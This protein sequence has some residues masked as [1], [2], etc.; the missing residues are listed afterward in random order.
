MKSVAFAGLLTAL[1]G[2]QAVLATAEWGQ[3]DG[4]GYG[5]HPCDAGLTCVYVNDYYSQCQK[6]TGATTTTSRP[7]GTT[8]T[9]TSV[10]TT[11][12]G[13]SPNT[14]SLNTKYKAKGKQYWGTCGDQ[15]TLSQSQCAQ[16]VKDDFGA[17]TPENSLKW[18]ATCVVFLYMVS[19][20]PL[21]MQ[22]G[23][24]WV[25]S[26]GDKNT[27]TTVI[28]NH[29][30]TLVTRYKGKIAKW[31]VVNEMFNEDG[32]VRS[33]VFSN[34]LGTTF[35][36]IAFNAA[37]AADGSAKLYINDYNLDSVNSKVNGLV[38]LVNQKKSAGVPIDGI[39]SQAH[40]SAGQT[41]GFLAALQKLAST[42]V[43]EVAVTELDIVNAASNDY[44]AI[45]N[46]CLQVP[47]CVGI[48]SWGV[49]DKDSWRAS[50]NP[51]LFNGSFQPK[52]AYTALIN[53]L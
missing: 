34:V 23:V 3:C 43:T 44:L 31:D 11:T 50:S 40:L 41:G 7:G 13:S 30:T 25:S 16:V 51:L 15:G 19:Y 14:N 1:F 4:I 24:H 10:T 8:T 18:D 36:D 45:S 37:R 49:S 27:L 32:S 53:S 48:T 52:P 26:I 17:L 33:S 22:P 2:A 29:A 39:G 38:N 28:Q 5:S 35:V 20:V 6:S 21:L 42:S 12:G 9:T 46:A 47:K